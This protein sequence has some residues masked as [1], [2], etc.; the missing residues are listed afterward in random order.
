MKTFFL[1]AAVFKIFLSSSNIIVKQLSTSHDDLRIQKM[2]LNQ[3][4]QY[5]EATKL[6]NC[7][8]TFTLHSTN[9]LHLLTTAR[10]STLN[11]KQSLLMYH[12]LHSAKKLN[13][14]ILVRTL[15]K[16]FCNIELIIL[17]CK[18]QTF[19]C[20]EYFMLDRTLQQ[21][22]FLKNIR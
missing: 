3:L 7:C 1:R 18:L 9:L 17:P 11:H 14:F 8:N 19:F 16:T 22:K 6:H 15:N 4:L 12:T 5:N 2:T 21:R 10:P 20:N 13:I